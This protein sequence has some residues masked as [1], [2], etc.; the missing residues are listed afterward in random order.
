[1]SW[2]LITLSA[3]ILSKALHTVTTLDS[4]S[5]LEIDAHLRDNSVFTVTCYNKGFL[6]DDIVTWMSMESIM[7]MIDY[8]TWI[9]TLRIVLLVLPWFN[10]ELIPATFSNWTNLPVKHG[11]V[12]NERICHFP[13]KAD[14]SKIEF[15]LWAAMVFI[16]LYFLVLPHA[17]LNNYGS[18]IFIWKVLW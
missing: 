11:K 13:A 4:I 10:H 1:M 16:Y 8:V 15:S 18:D 5:A 14:R 17:K 7:H 2:R 3:V 12:W 6:L 9:V